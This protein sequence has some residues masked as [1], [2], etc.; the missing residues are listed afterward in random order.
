[1]VTIFYCIETLN[2]FYEVCP[3]GLPRVVDPHRVVDDGQVVILIRR[4]LDEMVDQHNHRTGMNFLHETLGGIETFPQLKGAVH[5]VEIVS[6]LRDPRQL[7][8]Q[9]AGPSCGFQPANGFARG[10]HQVAYRQ[11][12]VEVFRWLR[13]LGL[14]LT[15]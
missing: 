9:E 13:A 6:I 12:L 14:C 2:D 15:R 5:E 11:V 4:T 1:M 7:A 10:V 8:W 3:A